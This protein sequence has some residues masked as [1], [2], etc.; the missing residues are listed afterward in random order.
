MNIIAKPAPKTRAAIFVLRRKRSRRSELAKLFE[1][2]TDLRVLLPAVFRIIINNND[3]DD[4]DAARANKDTFS[5]EDVRRFI[6]RAM[7]AEIED[8]WRVYQDAARAE[9]EPTL[10]TTE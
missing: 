10:G 3:Y 4:A 5:A 8:A 2:E 7:D 1:R 6:L 9:I